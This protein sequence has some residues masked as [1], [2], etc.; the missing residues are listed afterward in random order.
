MCFFFMVNRDHLLASMK[1]EGL[2]CGINSMGVCSRFCIERWTSIISI[3]PKEMTKILIAVPIRFV[4]NST[5]L[6]LTSYRNFFFTGSSPPSPTF[7]MRWI[8]FESL[9]KHINIIPKG[10]YLASMKDVNENTFGMWLYRWKFETKQIR[11]KTVAD[12]RLQPYLR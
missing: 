2:S 5:K 6:N 1:N 8:S 11:Y 9:Q 7:N 12:C 10:L 3:N 4:G